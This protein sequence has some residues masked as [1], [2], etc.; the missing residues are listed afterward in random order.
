[1]WEDNQLI[2]LEQAKGV[3]DAGSTK[4]KCAS[5]QREPKA[6]EPESDELKAGEPEA[7]EPEADSSNHEEESP[8]LMF[9]NR[10]SVTH[11]S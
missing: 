1:M 3:C 6:D 2:E 9:Q 10:H 7:D 11:Q 8:I 4:D 5:E